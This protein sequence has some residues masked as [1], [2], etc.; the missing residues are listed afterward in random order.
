ML[1]DKYGI[2]ISQVY[3]M[4]K[5]DMLFTS[6]A[7]ETWINMNLPDEFSSADF[8]DYQILDSGLV[9][10]LIKRPGK[11]KEL[12]WIHG[13][14]EKWETYPAS[15][16]CWKI[17]FLNENLGW[18]CG[19]TKIDDLNDTQLI[20]HTEDG[21]KTWETQW[22]Y[23]FFGF[24]LNG[25]KFINDSIGMATGGNAS[26]LSTYNGGKTWRF[27]TLKKQPD[28]GR[29]P[30]ILSPPEMPSITTAYVIVSGDYIYKYTRDW[31]L[32]A[33]DEGTESG[34][35]S[36][37]QNRPNPAAARTEISYTLS[38]YSHVKLNI[39]DML[40]NIRKALIDEYEGAGEHSIIFTTE[41]LPQ[42]TYFYRLETE[43]G[44]VAK[45]MVVFR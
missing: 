35:L 6:N 28:K 14:W 18:M 5:T 2:V 15:N 42:G 40:G 32:G 36:L 29:D 12:L 41:G 17:C 13:D 33:G 26:F 7:G 22:D 1:N 23:K 9:V 21:G 31:S 38:S 37:D 11:D 10:A 27:D 44:S 39:Y 45:Q 20:M 8:K 4:E 34:Q 43:K 19:G 3:G 25:I 30:N 16:Y 24:R